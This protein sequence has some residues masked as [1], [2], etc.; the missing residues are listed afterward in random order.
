LPNWFIALPVAPGPWLAA[1]GEPPPGAALLHPDD[2]HVTI[3]FLGSVGPLLAERAWA[4][5]DLQLG[6]IAADLDRVVA[7]GPPRRP[8]AF[9][10]VLGAGRG[11]V[12]AAMA[13]ARDACCDAAGARRE[14]RPP[15][16]HVTLVRPRRSATPGERA[17]TA[18]WAEGLAL[19]RPAIALDR[20]ALFTA[21]DAPGSRRYRTV[22]ER[23]LAERC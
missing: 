9:A 19:G 6:P 4:A 1:L 7:L 18:R 21:A 20:V 23:P 22:A 13:A 16:A 10:A 11:E 8:S 2:L 12:E 5:L 3:A 15:L 14:G 17:A